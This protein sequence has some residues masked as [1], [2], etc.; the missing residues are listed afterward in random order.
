M[1]FCVVQQVSAQANDKPSLMVGNSAPD[2][3]VEQWVKGGGAVPLQEGKV[4]IIDLWATWCVPCIVGMPHLSELQAKYKNKG[5][6]IIGITSE[7]KYGN[8]LENVKKF[9]LQKDTLMAY[10]VAWVP[11]S[12]NDSVHGIWLHPWMKESGLGNLPT[13]FLIDRNGKIVYIGDPVTVDETLASVMSGQYNIDVLKENY[14][15][16]IKAEEVLA[17][18][19]RAIKS[20][21]VDEALKYGKSIL[22]DFSYVKPNTYLVMGWQVAH[23]QGEPNPALLEMGYE[24][25]KRGMILTKFTS[26]AFFDVMAG[27]YAIRK[28]FLSAIAYE[29]LAVSMSEG[30][31]KEKQQ[32]NLN[33]YLELIVKN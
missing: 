21:D 10:N 26:P 32:L 28:D 8:T 9:V 25:A 15:Q 12:G 13:T 29:K 30:S 14:A 19:N 1:A 3:Q 11:K 18:F 4:Y 16:G 27:I 7:D 23:K 6:E 2:L 5:L 20:T 24:A 33:K 17:D 22:N 31:M